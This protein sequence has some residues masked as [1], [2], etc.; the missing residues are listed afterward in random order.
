MHGKKGK[1]VVESKELE[2]QIIE[3]QQEFVNCMCGM[4]MQVHKGARTYS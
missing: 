1:D 4:H 2:G 3:G